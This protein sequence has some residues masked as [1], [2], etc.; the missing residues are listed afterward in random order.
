MAVNSISPSN[1]FPAC[2]TS[3]RPLINCVQLQVEKSELNVFIQ[4]FSSLNKKLD[5]C[6]LAKVHVYDNLR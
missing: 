4:S 6:G 3:S 2:S 5:F 1:F